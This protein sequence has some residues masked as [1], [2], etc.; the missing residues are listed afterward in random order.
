MS[1]SYTVVFLL[2]ADI[3]LLNDSD[4]FDLCLLNDFM[5]FSLTDYFLISDSYEILLS[6]GENAFFN[7][8]LVQELLLSYTF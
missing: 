8:S 6:Y 5:D 7:R 1:F 2:I 4:R 3:S